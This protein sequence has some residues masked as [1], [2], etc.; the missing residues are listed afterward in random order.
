MATVNIVPRT[1]SEGQLG[2]ESKPWA[3]NIADSAKFKF[4]DTVTGQDLVF[5]NG[6]NEAFRISQG[7]NAVLFTQKLSGSVAS[8]ASF[9]RVQASAIGGNSPLIIDATN[10]RVD[11]AGGI[12]PSGNI[13]GSI[14]STGS[15]GNLFTA[16]DS[17]VRGQ[18]F[19]QPQNN[20]NNATTAEELS[21][22]QYQSGLVNYATV[23]TAQSRAFNAE[24]SVI[25]LQYQ[26]IDNQMN[27][28]LLLGGDLTN[29]I[30]QETL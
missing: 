30:Q 23:L 8:T 25:Q 15:F 7:Q 4:I 18:I 16:N 3:L 22:E 12:A 6:G 27:L 5:R 20:T 14:A 1:G 28:L 2:T 10:F 24:S 21:F 29:L 9:G 19:I 13:S 17:E 26:L 11:A